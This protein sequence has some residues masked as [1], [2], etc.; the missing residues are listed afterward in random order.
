MRIPTGLVGGTAQ[1]ENALGVRARPVDE[2]GAADVSRVKIGPFRAQPSYGDRFATEV[3]PGELS[4]AD[5]PALDLMLTLRP[6]DSAVPML[7]TVLG[8]ELDAALVVPE[9]A[10]PYPAQDP[11]RS[12]PR[13]VEEV[14]AQLKLSP[15]AAALYLMVLAL[16]DPTDRNTAAWTGWKPA[17]MKAARTELG[18][19]PLVVTGTRPR[20]GRTMFLPGGWHAFGAPLLPVEVWKSRWLGIDGQGRAA[21]QITVPRLPVPE[22]FEAA[23]RRVLDGDPPRLEELSTGR[24]R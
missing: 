2:H 7:R 16:P 23:W 20:A 3:A 17:R 10:E 8:G 5:D 22:L 11:T 9:A 4:G 1:L 15:D 21:L 18:A 12:V 13:L 14:A 19:T 6:G 24:R